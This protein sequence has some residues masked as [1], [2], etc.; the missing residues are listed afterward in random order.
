MKMNMRRLGSILLCLFVLACFLI[1]V[2]AV[3]AQKA[4]VSAVPLSL[5]QTPLEN[6]RIQGQSISDLFSRLALRYDIPIG[7]E[8]ARPGHLQSFY[9]I[10]FRKGTL[11]ELLT[12]F[13]AEHDEYTWKI[14]DGVVRIFPKDAYRDSL[15]NRLLATQINNFSVAKRTV[16][17]SLSQSLF[18]TPEIETIVEP[19]EL[20]NGGENF[21][22]FFFPQLGKEFS[23]S[24]SRMNSK[25]ILDK[26]IKESPT[27]K[28]WTISNNLS[29][30]SVTLIVNAGFE[31]APEDRYFKDVN[32]DDLIDP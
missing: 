24:V 8:I 26:V 25:S 28:L 3:V 19:Y 16:T 14:E 1:L 17:W 4:V 5:A 20:R 22:G 2:D 23:F 10:E 21:S 15:V 29:D 13:V 18:S 30:R 31:Y 6:V 12:Q 11:S 7:L 32:L 27:A 9:R